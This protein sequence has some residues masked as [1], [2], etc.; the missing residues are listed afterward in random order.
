MPL[1][2]TFVD[3]LIAGFAG[4]LGTYLL[5]VFMASQEME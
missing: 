1:A 4:G 3:L 5:I 2:Y